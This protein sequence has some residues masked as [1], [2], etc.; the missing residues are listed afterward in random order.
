MTTYLEAETTQKIQ[1]FIPK[2][3]GGSRMNAKSLIH[4]WPVAGTKMT[5]E[6]IPPSVN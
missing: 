5:G 4:L 2:G 3:L 6:L 1:D